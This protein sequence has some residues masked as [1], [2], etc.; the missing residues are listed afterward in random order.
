MVSWAEVKDSMETALNM[1]QGN[2]V[3]DTFARGAIESIPGAGNILIK[4]YDKY[5]ETDAEDTTLDVSNALN[6][7]NKMNEEMFGDFCKR[8]ENNSEQILGNRNYLKQLTSD[9][10]KILEKLDTANKKLEGVEHKLGSIEEKL[11]QLYTE[12]QKQLETSKITESMF[13][14]IEQ[15]DKEITLLREQLSKQGKNSFN[16]DY[17]FKQSQAYYYAKKYE[18]SIEIIDTILLENPDHTSSLNLKGLALLDLGKTEAAR[19]YFEKALETN[20]DDF[21][22]AYNLGTVLQDLGKHEMATNYFI[23]ALQKRPMT[24]GYVRLAESLIT[25]GKND[26]AQE[27]LRKGISFHPKS[28]ELEALLEKASSK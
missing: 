8:L 9:T 27:Y 25:L 3:L 22:I 5:A 18:K 24:K 16:V 7:M 1:V 14:K 4:F 20:P 28:T 11:T 6:T 15:R 12:G 13:L 21:M 17:Y 23:K 10:A 26:L 2:P 19:M